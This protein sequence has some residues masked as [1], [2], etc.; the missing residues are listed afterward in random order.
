LFTSTD[1]DNSCG[2]F[3]AVRPFSD[4]TSGF[5]ARPVYPQGRLGRRRANGKRAFFRTYATAGKARRLRNNPN[6]EVAPAT[7]SGK[8]TGPALRARARRLDGAE[9]AH[10]AELINRKH[11][12]FQGVLVRLGH[13]LMRYRTLHYGLTPVDG[14]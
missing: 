8:A 12:F 11:P 14:S 13:R 7:F 3:W 9:A 5:P 10:A 6:V 2:S 1:I 4:H